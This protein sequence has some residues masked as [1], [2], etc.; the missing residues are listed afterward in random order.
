V[1]DPTARAD[2]DRLVD[3]GIPEQMADQSPKTF[4]SP[5]IFKTAFKDAD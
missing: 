3:L 5:K 2:I 4:F 1:T